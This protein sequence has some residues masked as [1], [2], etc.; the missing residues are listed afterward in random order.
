MVLC[1]RN[2]FFVDQ[3]R[4][5]LPWVEDH[6]DVFNDAAFTITA[7]DSMDFTP[8]TSPYTAVPLVSHDDR[9]DEQCAAGKRSTMLQWNIVY[10][11]CRDI[12]FL[13]LFTFRGALHLTDV[14]HPV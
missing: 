6:P 9:D 4:V 8:P 1:P 12:N 5:S 10:G 14:V 3:N 13:R 11:H 2:T 7:T